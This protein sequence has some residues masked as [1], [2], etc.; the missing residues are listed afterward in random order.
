MKKKIKFKKK[1]KHQQME[2]NPKTFNFDK[3]Q[4]KHVEISDF[5]SPGLT[6]L[7][8]QESNSFKLA[9]KMT[10]YEKPRSVLRKSIRVKMIDSYAYYHLGDLLNMRMLDPH[11][12][13]KELDT[14]LS[15]LIKNGNLSADSTLSSHIYAGEDTMFILDSVRDMG[16]GDY[17]F[18]FSTCM[19]GRIPLYVSQKWHDRHFEQLKA[20]LSDTNTMA[21]TA[22][23]LLEKHAPH[24][25]EPTH[26]ILD[27][28]D[29]PHIK[30][31]RESLDTIFLPDKTKRTRS[32]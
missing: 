12:A 27:I 25:T 20:I 7:I 32:E 16:F 9:I 30:R 26:A 18:F 19:A 10:D 23:D 13:K 1:K 31:L 3:L 2:P 4:P 24:V 8:P 28:N 22:S 15:A 6:V 5:F 17:S 21:E 29:Y 11:T 14:I